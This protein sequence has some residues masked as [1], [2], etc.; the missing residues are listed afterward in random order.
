M[1]YEY[2][3]RRSDY[4]GY[5]EIPETVTYQGKTY[6]VTSIGEDAFYYCSDLTSIV[7]PE[8]VTSI[9]HRAFCGCSSL[10]GIRIPSNVTFI[11]NLAFS[12]CYS[13]QYSTYNN[14]SYLGNEYNPYIVLVKAESKDITSCSIQEG[15]RIIMEHAFD[16]CRNLTSVNMPNTVVF[17]GN[18]AFSYCSSLESL[19]LSRSLT[20]IE[21]EAFYECSNLSSIDIP[22]GI[23]R[24][25]GYRVFYGCDNLQYNE[26]DNGLY[27]GNSYN[28]YL[29]L[30]KA[31]TTDI[32]SCSVADG[33]RIICNRAFA[34][35]SNLTSIAIPEG[36]VS[37]E[38]YAF[39]GCN[40]L[41]S[42]TI[43]SSIAFIGQCAF[44]C[45]NLTDVYCLAEEVPETESNAFNVINGNYV[46]N[47]TLHVPLAS[48]ESYRSTKPWSC[49]GTI[50]AYY[51]PMFDKK[52]KGIWYNCDRDAR[53]ASVIRPQEG[54][55]Y[56]GDIVIPATIEFD[57]MT[58][59]VTIIDDYAFAH[60]G[61]NGGFSSN[62][63][64]VT[65]PE[66]VTYIGEGA[67]FGCGLPNVL[68]K[69][70]I[71]PEAYQTSFSEPTY[72]H[73]KL[74]V[75]NGCWYDYAF[76]Y[77]WYRF[78]NIRET[79]MAEEQLS[80]QQ[81][82]TLMDAGT[83]AYSVYDPVNGRISPVSNI[84]ED[85]PNHCWQV[86]EAE[87]EHYLYN[88][89][90][91]KFAVASADGTLTLTEAPTAIEMGDGEDGIVLGRQASRQWAFVGNDRMNVEDAIADGIA[92][93]YRTNETCETNGSFDLAGRRISKLQRGINIIR[94]SDGTSK[95]VL[96]K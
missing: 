34:D 66:T 11:D 24:I 19:T 50:V 6:R 57:G 91:K 92:E 45:R 67:F 65:I 27:L 54:E 21:E 62:I 51:P 28:P 20:Y 88:L 18:Y 72:Y 12:R 32:T 58:F 49:F 69:G 59:Y 85:N 38:R 3:D 55:D 44:Y 23:N 14:V 9:G 35:Y 17:I 25:N 93:T 81:A 74:Y 77:G 80:M 47:A 56:S 4:K 13:L 41:T 42:V 16:G 61:A 46:E 2:D 5:I 1:T 79:T 82:Y 33:C 22:D 95:K 89:G 37:I 29:V 48:I 7:L 43:P 76:N 90:A 86:I 36:V 63:T 15:C 71:P 26:Y 68:V 53:F 30:V 60:V 83:F 73:A 40:G 78:L 75:P 64:S 84:N 8:S 96:V 31:K 94:Y 39:Y 10:A 70:T 87:G 52:V